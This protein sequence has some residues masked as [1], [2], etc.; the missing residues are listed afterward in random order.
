MRGA[1]AR[2]FAVTVIDNFVTGRRSNLAPVLDQ[3]DLVEGSIADPQA[4]DRAM[5]GVDFVLHEAALPSVPKS[6]ERPVDTHEAN[7]TGTLQLLEGARRAGVKRLVYAGS[8]SAYGPNPAPVK[9]EDM[10]PQP[11]SPYA[12]QKLT[13]EYYLKVYHQLFGL[14]TITLRYFNVFGPRQDPKS[15]YAAVVPAFVTRMLRGEAPVV[16]G[17]G[18]QSRDFTF[19]DNVVEANFAALTAPATACGRVFNAACGGNIDLLT[20]IEWINEALGTAIVPTHVETRAGDVRHSCADT[21][22]AAEG[23]GWSAR[24]SVA[25]GLRRTIEWYQADAGQAS[26]A[27]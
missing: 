3:I 16:H 9:R 17:D 5:A 18:R 13:G 22:A 11:I 15:Q 10:P 27:E 1:L 24:I 23:L 4:V 21:R 7:I 14:E 25:E 20:L 2:G 6:V 12:V 19:I 8:S 26:V